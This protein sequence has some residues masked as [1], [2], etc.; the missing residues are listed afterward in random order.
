MNQAVDL[1]NWLL[2]AL[3][4]ILEKMARQVMIEIF[5]FV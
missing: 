1:K 5:P 3:Q 4:E 2:V